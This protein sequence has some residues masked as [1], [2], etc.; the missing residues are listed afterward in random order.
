VPHPSGAF[1]D[2]VMIDELRTS[3]IVSLLYFLFLVCLAWLRPAPPRARFVVTT[4]AV[5]IWLTN[6]IAAGLAAVS[7]AG[8]VAVLRDWLPLPHLLLAYWLPRVLIVRA[9]VPLERWLMAFDERMLSSPSGLAASRAPRPVKELLELSYTAVYPLVPFALGLLLLYGFRSEVDRFWT[10]VLLAEYACY[11]LLPLVPTR[12]PRALGRRRDE[13][14]VTM[15]RFNTWILAGASNGW[16]TFP[17]GHVAGSVACG[18][19]VWPSL[20][21]A[22]AALIVVAVMIAAASVLGRYHYAADALAGAAVAALA[23]AIAGR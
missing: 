10:T 8:V 15:R 2:G 1:A 21:A 3:E 14:P 16:N 23:F 17:S 6:G 20:P 22:G 7:T 9:H 19:A 5:A 12:P 13:E 18:L 4:V 11:G